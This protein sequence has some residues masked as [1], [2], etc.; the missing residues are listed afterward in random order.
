VTLIKNFEFRYIS[1]VQQ[2]LRLVLLT[3]LATPFLMGA[4]TLLHVTLHNH[5]SDLKR[6]TAIYGIFTVHKS[7]KIPRD[8]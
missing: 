6:N 4:P 3:L 8:G 1:R 7:F 2:D 5:F